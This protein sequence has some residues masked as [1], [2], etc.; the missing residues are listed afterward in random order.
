MNTSTEFQ[1]NAPLPQQE[2]PS[3]THNQQHP[4]KEKTA[5]PLICGIGSIVFSWTVVIGG[6]LA[7]LAFVFS[8][9]Y[10]KASGK[11]KLNTAG[12][13]C[14]IIGI[15]LSVLFLLL[16][17]INPIIYNNYPNNQNSVESTRVRQVYYTDNRKIENM[18]SDYFT[19]LVELD[20]KK[21][22]DIATRYDNLF[23]DEFSFS[24]T[25]A[26][27][28]PTVIAEMSAKSISYTIETIFIYDDIDKVE[29]FI[30]A[31]STDIET[32][33]STLSAEIGKLTISGD[34]PLISS[35]SPDKA[36]IG[37]LFL[38]ACDT[39]YP[40]S[41]Y[42]QLVFNKVGDEWKIDESSAQRTENALFGL[43][44]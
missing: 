20:D 38:Q 32:Y 36:R 24:L 28:D 39:S 1:H 34:A 10:K 2:P 40:T 9:Q 44:T 4:R 37:T 26:E 31:E 14:G 5:I 25:Q 41:K 27:I 11:N 19:G 7:T 35:D 16:Y 6:I 21:N 15:V 13:V 8:S 42:V 12:R 33:M 22:K 3:A 17:I 30:N 23:K 29:V 18:C 43:S